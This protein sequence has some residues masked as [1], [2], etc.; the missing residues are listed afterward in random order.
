M[1]IKYA[2]IIDPKVSPFGI[3]PITKMAI[4]LGDT[5]GTID[6]FCLAFQ[7]NNYLKKEWAKAIAN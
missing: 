6:H 1:N 3:A 2:N 5:G 4:K 7:Y